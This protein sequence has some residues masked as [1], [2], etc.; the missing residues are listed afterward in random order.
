MLREIRRSSQIETM[1]TVIE[2]VSER[3]TVAVI[4]IDEG[5]PSEAARRGI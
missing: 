1:C 2:G 3:Q 5:G 4:A